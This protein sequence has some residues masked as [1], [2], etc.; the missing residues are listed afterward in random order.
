MSIDEIKNMIYTFCGIFGGVS[1]VLSAI[2][3][4]IGKG[5]ATKISQKGDARIQQKLEEMRAELE[6]IKQKYRGN[7]EQKINVHKLKYE[8]EMQAYSGIWESIMLYRRCFERLIQIVIS[9]D[10][11]KV[12]V[13][14]DDFKEMY[15]RFHLAYKE[16]DDAIHGHAPFIPD[17]I[18]SLLLPLF[19]QCGFLGAEIDDITFSDEFYLQSSHVNEVSTLMDRYMAINDMVEK[20]SSKIR[21]HLDA[22]SVIE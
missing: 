10:K 8:K 15:S 18:Y 7:V 2:I 14:R 9:C 4:W 5:L 20:L 1:I 13:D 6:K 11:R 17:D 3:A 21:E 12:P 16:V 19:N 22:I